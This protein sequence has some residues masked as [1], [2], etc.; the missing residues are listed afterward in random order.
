MMLLR[1]NS[2]LASGRRVLERIAHQIEQNLAE[3][4]FIEAV[5]A[6]VE[7]GRGGVGFA[8]A[9]RDPGLG[10]ALAAIYGRSERPWTLEELAREAGMSR[11]S[12]ARR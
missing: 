3:A 7:Q 12:F 11:A 6:S 2:H 8:A 1:Q 5:R 10:A 9:L 4:V